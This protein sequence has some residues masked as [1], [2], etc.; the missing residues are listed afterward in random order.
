MGKSPSIPFG[1]FIVGFSFI[2]LALV[3]GIYYSFSVF[4]VALLKEFG[5]NRATGAGAFSL[6]MIVNSLTAP[7]IGK[8]VSSTHPKRVMIGGMILLGMGLMLS[9]LTQMWWQFYLFFSFITAIGLGA[10]GWLPNVVIVQNWFKEKRGLAIGIISAG[11]GVGIL[12]CV[13]SAQ[14]LILQFGWRIAYRIMAIFIPLVVI[15]MAIVF[16]RNPPSSAQKLGKEISHKIEKDPSKTYGKWYPKSWTVAQAVRTKVFWLLGF[17]FFLANLITQALFTHQ[18]AFFVDCGLE[19]LLASYIVGMIGIVSLGGKILWGTLSDRIG[20]EITYT[21]GI[22]CTILGIL[23]L[24][25]FN[26]SPL[27]ALPYLY[28][29]F[30]GMGYAVHAALPPLI[31]ADFFEGR[32]YGGIFGLHMIFIGIGGAFGAWFAGFLHDRFGSYLPL[33]IITILCAF[34]S[35]LNI[36]WA[37]PKRIRMATEGGGKSFDP[38]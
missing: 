28:A 31:V 8:M 32:G 23:W 34:F 3:Y 10:T 12:V 16:L 36:W 15:S 29:F 22:T 4:F 38:F 2:T 33:F 11:V 35:C 5:W 26:H 37:G 1:W 30:F 21:M 6:F 14:Y 27:A 7:F 20:R 24:I 25:L 17:S 19:A 18:V 9:S 13:P